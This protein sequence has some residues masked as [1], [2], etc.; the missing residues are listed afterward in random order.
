MPLA[1]RGSLRLSSCHP[2]A[3]SVRKNHTGTSWD[4]LSCGFSQSDDTLVSDFTTMV[5]V[6]P[7]DSFRAPGAPP[8]ALGPQPSESGAAIFGSV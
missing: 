7:A 2:V 4:T 3:T 6:N 5:D 1:A 8:A